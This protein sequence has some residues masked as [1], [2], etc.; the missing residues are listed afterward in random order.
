MKCEWNYNKF[1]YRHHSI[2]GNYQLVVQES[3]IYGEDMCMWV[4]Y[5]YDKVI[6]E[7]EV[8]GWK[9]AR[10]LCEVVVETHMEEK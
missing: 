2:K 1:S 10:R 7:G 9:L 8:M 4:V 5:H 3:V 6:A